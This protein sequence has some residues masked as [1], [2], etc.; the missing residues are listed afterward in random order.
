M[1]GNNRMG[2]GTADRQTRSFDVS[3]R[4]LQ[5]ALIRPVINWQQHLDNRNLDI[6]HDSG[7]GNIQF[8][9]VQF[10]LLFRHFPADARFR[11]TRVIGFR[12]LEDFIILARI[13]VRY[14]IRIGGDGPGLVKTVPPVGKSRV[15]QKPGA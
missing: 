3:G 14:G 7:S 4:N 13:H 15:R 5:H 11:N 6:A 12:A 2:P 9:I 1:P 10:P 8:L